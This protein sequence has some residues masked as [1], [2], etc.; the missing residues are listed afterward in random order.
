MIYQESE[1][2]ELRQTMEIS[3]LLEV[4]GKRKWIVAF[5]TVFTALAGFAY[6]YF[7]VNPMYRADT[8][9][10]VSSSKGTVSADDPASY[11]DIGRISVNQ[12]IAVT[13][14]EIVKS[15]VVLEPVIEELDLDM[16]YEELLDRTVSEPVEATEIIRISVEAESR[17]DAVTIANKITEVFVEEVV[18]ILKVNNVEIIDRAAATEEPVNMSPVALTAI[19]AAAGV[20]I[21][22]LVALIVDYRDNTLKSAE[23]IER[24]IGIPV[25]GSIPDFGKMK[26]D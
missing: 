5:I 13:Y 21:G 15:R 9:L 22:I 26:E 17:N 23:D 2:S 12:M 4:L 24:Q 6:S 10:M 7:L 11:I 20:V 25:I 14:G 19:A 3:E 8:T 16:S 1:A 18:R